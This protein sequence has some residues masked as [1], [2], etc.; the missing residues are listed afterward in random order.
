[1]KILCFEIPD[2]ECS[3]PTGRNQFIS[4]VIK[5]KI[6]DKVSVKSKIPDFLTSLYVPKLNM[7][8]SAC[9]GKRFSIRRKIKGNHNLSMPFEFTYNF[10]GGQLN[11]H[12]G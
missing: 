11:H 4:R 12:D 6:K 9:S 1:L 7:S 8:V 2:I 3:I 10:S 5:L